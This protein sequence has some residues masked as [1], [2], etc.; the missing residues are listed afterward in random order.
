MLLLSSDAVELL[1]LTNAVPSSLN[2]LLPH[3][4][5][6]S[7]NLLHDAFVTCARTGAPIDVEA[8]LASPSA[9][10]RWIRLVGEPAPSQRNL[11]I[12]ICG[13]IQDISAH[14]QVRDE[15]LRLATR[16]TTTLASITEAFMTLDRNA[17]VM[18]A[19]DE[20][21]KLLVQPAGTLLGTP[22]CGLLHGRN[23]GLLQNRIEQ[24]LSNNQQIGFEDFYPALDKWIEIR[25]HPYSEGLVLYLNDVSDRRQAQHLLMLLRT[26]IEHIN[27][28]VAIA[29]VGDT[30][31]YDARITFV[32]EAFEH[33]TGFSRQEVIG[34]SPDIL[35]HVTGTDIVRLLAR[36]ALRP[37]ALT[38]LL[39]R[40]VLLKRR[41]GSA[42]WMDLDVVPVRDDQG[43]LTH[44][45]AVGRDVTERKLAEQKIHR[46]A[47]FDPLTGL[48]NRQWLV[49][50]LEDALADCALT[51]Q[52]GAL[53]FIDLDNFNLLN[54]T[55][56]HTQ[57]DLL[58]QR[59]S[60]RLTQCLRKTDL[61]ARV[62]GDEFVVLLQNLGSEPSVVERKAQAVA[63]KVLAELAKPFELS[64]YLH[65]ST[66][67][68]GIAR[69]GTA[70][71][72]VRELLMQAGLARYQAKEMDGD[73][74]AFFDPA[75]QS[76]VNATA[77]LVADLRSAVLAEGQFSV[78]YQPQFDCERRMVAVEALL[79]WRHPQRGMVSPSEFIPIAEKTGLIVPLGLWVLEQACAQLAVWARKPQ[80]AHL[81]IAVNVSV[82]QFRHPAFV[83]QVISI[84]SR[85]GAPPHL[86][87]LELTESLLIDRLD[88][89]ISRMNS[90]KRLGVKFSLD[91][92]GTGYSSLSYLKRLPL[93]QLKIDKSFV[94][95]V[96]VDPSDA[97]IARTVIELAHS[98][99]MPALAEGVET[100]AQ[101]KFLTDCGCDLLQGFL[102]A[103]PMPMEGLEEFLQASVQSPMSMSD[104]E[105][106]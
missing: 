96:L 68:I 83:D 99:N 74:I 51:E 38:T 11:V 43:R 61:V 90:L 6:D 53:I 13:A 46:L 62:G 15:T 81:S 1:G 29:Q 31:G 88:T 64:D 32:N 95:D 60:E 55:M 25:A 93:D 70:S 7:A 72:R 47:F 102:L 33:K 52:E 18:Y 106:L 59:V 37:N 85:Y 86:L 78:E 50:R 101:C 49:D 2:E 104:L 34:Q 24:A 8:R 105:R 82:R 26:G 10:V 87:Q 28:V 56:G 5:P 14:R 77:A 80:T 16:L 91:D 58:L 21:Q 94:A 17:R 12:E 9:K 44:W 103:K 19:N 97:A 65:Y 39:R 23:E 73:A 79:R 27:D 98:L 100:E 45:M 3:F 41:D 42:Y 71:G 4:T 54:N 66:T 35:R 30:A 57:G 67:S 40:E 36:G 76:A 20:S 22:I 89:T 92:F 63:S 75:T 69:F 84:V 48:P